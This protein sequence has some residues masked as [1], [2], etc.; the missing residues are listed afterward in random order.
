ME[1]RKDYEDYSRFINDTYADEKVNMLSQTVHS[2][3]KKGNF[4][5]FYNP[6]NTLRAQ[7]S[8]RNNNEVI[9]SKALGQKH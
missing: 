6:T 9:R 7:S 5:K 8:S 3:H 2:E 1:P 4:S